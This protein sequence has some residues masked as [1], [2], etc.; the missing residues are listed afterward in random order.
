[1]SRKSSV[2]ASRHVRRYALGGISLLSALLSS[3]AAYAEITGEGGSDDIIV[4]A[5]R[6]NEAIQDVPLTVA[7]INAEALETRGV[8]TEADLQIAIPGL[9]VRSSNNSNQ[10]NYV[11]RG[12]SVDAYSGSPPGV[13]PYINE[14]PF[15]TISSTAFYDLANVQAVKGP[16]GT[17]FGRNST[18]G[19]VLFQTQE[20]KDEFGGYASIQ[21]GNRDRLIAEAALNLALASDKVLVRLAGTATSGG[22]FVR[23]L[24][25]DKLLGDSKE[26]SGRITVLLRPSEAFTNTTMVQIGKNTGTNA[27]NTPYY[28]IPC[29]DAYGFNS[30]T[31]SPSN[32]PFFDDLL[33]GRAV[34]GYPTGYVYPGGFEALPAFLR[35]QGKY[36]VDANAPFIHRA[37][38]EMVVNKSVLELSPEITIKNVFGFSFSKNA[39]NYD[40]DYSPYPIVQQYA[41]AAALAGGDLP[42]ETSTTRTWSDEL[43]LQGKT[44][45]DRL[46][47]L[48]GVFYIDSKE[49]YFSPLWIGAADLSVAYNAA[50]GNKSFAV[51]GQATYKVT[52]QLNLTVGG[53]YTW[54]KIN[55]TQLAQSIFGAGQPQHAKQSDPSWTVSLD[56]H[57]TPD[58]MFYATTR[59]SWR[60]GGF[61]PFNPPTATPTTAATG[62]GGNYFLPETVRDAEIGFKFDSRAAGIPIRANVA[63]YESWVKNIQKTAYTVIGGTVSSATINVPKARI[64]G[65]EAD[66]FARPAQ[67]LSLGTTLTYTDPKFT[68]A[69]SS[70]FGQPVVY[71]PF[72]DVPKFS[73]SVYGDVTIPLGGDAGS[74]NYHAEVYNQSSFYFSNLGGSLQPGTRL[75]GYSLVNM[76]LDW[77]EIMGSKVKASLF[78]KN[79]TGKV[80]YTGGSA[81]AQNFSVESATFGAPRTYG[82]VLRTDF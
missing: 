24:Y 76:R 12:E 46:N 40:T 25:D 29:G 47:Y 28:T 18:G 4:T 8:R 74:L 73:G 59:G 64:R 13:Q 53:R 43:Q 42:I 75:P 39:I 65:V 77:S 3:T 32:Q 55:L 31:Y 38:S 21:Y 51:F 57:V 61:N 66:F 1:M 15:P 50:T 67:W 17:L 22:A 78:V 82:I 27:P 2:P 56:Y 58:L 63:L 54:E 7:A 62:S 70:L 44:S 79:L 30:C 48:V 60:R 80:Y 34:P 35:S 26:R 20:P 69:T 5:R 14:V 81:G 9:L 16:Q 36:V 19:A 49:D 71:G 11:M 6:R 41:P 52:D 23:N 37:H 10:L 45:D 72:G 33:A 68:Q